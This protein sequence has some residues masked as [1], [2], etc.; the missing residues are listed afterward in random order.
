[1]LFIVLAAAIIIIIAGAVG[2]F[3][4]IS[5]RKDIELVEGAVIWGIVGSALIT[6]GY[7]AMTVLSGIIG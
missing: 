1:M 4:A 3:E 6:G 7:A 5:E 2:V